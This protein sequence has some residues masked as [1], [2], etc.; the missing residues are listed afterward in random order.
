[1]TNIKNIITHSFFGKLLVFAVSLIVAD[2]LAVNA[3]ADLLFINL[4]VGILN[5]LN[6]G[7][8][9]Y[10]YVQQR[11]VSLTQLDRLI[12]L[13]II[14]TIVITATAYILL[15]FI[16]KSYGSLKPWM[17]VAPL[18]LVA[19]LLGRRNE[20]YAT[21]ELDY[22]ILSRA[23]MINSVAV[24]VT[25]CILVFNGFGSILFAISY[26]IGPLVSGMY[27]FLMI[28]VPENFRFSVVFPNRYERNFNIS[29]FLNNAGSFAF[30]Q[31]DKVLVSMF[32]P[33]STVGF[34]QFSWQI[35]EI[36]WKFGLSPFSSYILA[37]LPR[38]LQKP[39][40]VMGFFHVISRLVNYL[41][42][43]ASGIFYLLLP[44]IMFRLYGDKWIEALVGMRVVVLGIIFRMILYPSNGIPTSLGMPY[45]KSQVTVVGS[46]IGVALIY[47]QNVLFDR[48][49]M[50]Y[51]SLVVFVY[52]IMDFVVFL[53]AMKKVSV[54]P[55]QWLRL[56]FVGLCQLLYLPIVTQWEINIAL[57]VVP[58]LLVILLG[59]YL[60]REDVMSMV[61]KS[62]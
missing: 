34:Y 27:N 7:G 36:P 44:D 11:E 17:L 1:M 60:Y 58:I 21:R 41:L 8:Y 29:F 56:R 25:Q 52:S 6:V 39:R 30:K 19:K 13:R 54:T 40:N 2:R 16:H 51:I 9:E 10:L 55:C 12:S 20:T 38:I 47:F 43:P 31:M 46:L 32:L 15:I 33:I 62:G 42:V 28:K 5:V 3:Y 4:I 48:N 57:S 18:I 35:G 37:K 59:I 24:A 14:H 26:V 61:K 49:L 53:R 23:S 22:A 50:N 45:I